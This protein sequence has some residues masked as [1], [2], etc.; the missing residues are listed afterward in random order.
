MVYTIS[1]SSIPTFGIIDT[2]NNAKF[3]AYVRDSD[4]TIGMETNHPLTINTNNTERMRITAAGNVGI[5]TTSPG[6]LLHVSSG[7][8]GDA[9]VIIESDT[10]NDNEND[11]PQL[12]FKQD[13]GNTIAKIGLSGDAGTIFTNSLANTAYFGND[14]A[15]SV[16][17]YTNATARL[18]IESGGDVGI[19]TASPGRKLEVAGDVGINGYIYHNGDD[20]RI[21]F[22]GNDA[23]RMYTANSVRLQ[24]N[25][26]GNVGIGTTSPTYKLTVS[27]GGIQ[28]GGKVTYTKS[29]GSL[30]TTGNAVAGLTTGNNGASCVFT[31][32]CFGGTGKYQRIVYSCYNDSGTW[33]PKKVIDEGTNHLDVTASADGTT[34]T[35]TFKAKSSSQSYT[36]RVTVEATG[37]SINSTYA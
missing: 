25:S 9:V 11:N 29:Y 36:P 35:F 34:I 21:G 15:A 24:I 10:D 22:E 5:G 7:T 28:A 19:G 16:Q 27:G 6:G 12:Q 33:R 18:T 37:S 17:L 13:G 32:T 31:F 4:A 14:E 20:S 23:I 2:T 3:T 1:G 26:S 30:N 8:S